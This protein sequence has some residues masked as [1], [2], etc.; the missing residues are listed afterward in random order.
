[1]AHARPAL[2]MTMIETAEI[3]A[4]R[5]SVSREAQ[6][7]YALRSQQRTA[8]AQ[9]AGRFDDEIVPLPSTMLVDRQGHRRESPK[10]VTLDKDEGNRAGHH[11]RGPRRR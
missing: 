3:V 6:D 5:Y 8:A 11:A 10:A 2:Y 4:D 7:E 1:M 9:A